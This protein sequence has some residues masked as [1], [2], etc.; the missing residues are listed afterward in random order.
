MGDVA[1]QIINKYLTS[2]KICDALGLDPQQIHSLKIILDS[3]MPRIEIVMPLY[4]D[5]GGMLSAILLKEFALVTKDG[6]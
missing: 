5:R 6:G 3:G 4:S 2:A 1:D